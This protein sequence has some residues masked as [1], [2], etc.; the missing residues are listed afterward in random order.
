M[1]KSVKILIIV[2]CLII[3]GLAVFIVWDKVIN[4]KLNVS[5][6]LEMYKGYWYTDK[7]TGESTTEYTELNIKNINGNVITF[8][9][10]LAIICADKD[11]TTEIKDG[12]GEF[13]TN[14]SQGSIKLSDNK[15]ELKVKNINYDDTDFEKVFS[16]KSS[17]SRNKNIV[18]NQEKIIGEWQIKR[19]VDLNT[20]TDMGYSQH[21]GNDLANKY[22]FEF[23][24]NGTYVRLLGDVDETGTYEVVENKV[25]MHSKLGTQISLQITEDEDKNLILIE[26]ET[27]TNVRVYYSKLNKTNVLDSNDEQS[28]KNHDEN[29]TIS[30]PDEI[31]IVSDYNHVSS[32][33]G[34]MKVTGFDLNSNVVWTYQTDTFDSVEYRC[35][36]DWFHTNRA[37]IIQSEMITVLNALNG[38]I[39]GSCKIPKIKENESFT[40]IMATSVNTQKGIYYVL[41]RHS[42]DVNGKDILYKIDDSGNIVGKSDIK[43]DFET[44]TVY[45]I[46]A[47]GVEVSGISV[48]NT[49]KTL[50]CTLSIDDGGTETRKFDIEFK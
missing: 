41:A 30:N 27:E 33:S 43:G 16:Y 49:E 11:I 10:T 45:E 50:E 48:D 6:N 47:Q 8:D 32:T 38:L 1:K 34:Y 7:E 5:E 46:F 39:V 21:F 25:N 28:N 9:Y 44:E 15:V 26:N 19:I 31:R 2:L 42:Y 14:E 17:G 29:K 36:L 3:V 24:N 13:K 20:N 37:Y 18:N 40:D 4:R 22:H 23:Y 12:K 35:K